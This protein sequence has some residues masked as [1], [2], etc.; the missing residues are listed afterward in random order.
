MFQTLL[1]PGHTKGGSEGE[2]SDTFRSR[3]DG[4]V[5]VAEKFKAAIVIVSGRGPLPTKTE[6]TL[7]YHY[8]KDRLP[9]YTKILKEEYS[10]ETIANYI[11]STAAVIA[12][13]KIARVVTVTSPEQA[14]RCHQ[15]A[16]H[17]WGNRVIHSVFSA[18]PEPK[19]QDPEST[20]ETLEKAQF[21]D[22]KRADFIADF[23]AS[24]AVTLQE[25]L[26]WLCQNYEDRQKTESYPSVLEVQQE[27]KKG[28][29]RDHGWGPLVESLDDPTSEL[30]KWWTRFSQQGTARRQIY[31]AL[32]EDTIEGAHAST[33]LNAQLR[34]IVLLSIAEFG[35]LAE[36]QNQMTDLEIG[37]ILNY[38]PVKLY[39]ALE[40]YR[41]L[42]KLNKEDATAFRR[43]LKACLMY[44]KKSGRMPVE[45]W[46]GQGRNANSRDYGKD[47][48]ESLLTQVSHELE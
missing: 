20:K 34:R 7:G 10:N 29:L 37:L 32:C 26:N 44:L 45:V 4:A 2:L 39:Y 27:S 19:N 28:Q 11:F 16:Q 12:P 41:D 46:P 18:I 30:S 36:R 47:E 3:L 42:D 9:S 35:H 31:R 8:L 22:L 5:T 15:I 1:V 33:R 13:L 48:L 25:H 23:L 38:A 43:V 17:L 14:N 21:D 40:G 24:G 6:A